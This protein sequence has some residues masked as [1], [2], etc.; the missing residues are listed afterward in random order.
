MIDKKEMFDIIISK[1]L[2]DKKQIHEKSY[3]SDLYDR[4]SYEYSF[5]LFQIIENKLYVRSKKFPEF[6]GRFEG[7]KAHI[8]KILD[9]Y[10]LP[11]MEFVY[12]DGDGLNT[13]DLILQSASC[14]ESN[15]AILVPDWSFQFWPETYLFDYGTDLDKIIKAAE[16]IG[17][18]IKGW[19]TKADVVF[20]RG[21]MNN[22]YREQY[23]NRGNDAFLDTRHIP[24]KSSHVPPGIPNFDISNPNG[25]NGI[26]RSENS[27]YKFLLHLNGG[28]DTDYS[29]GLRF[30]LACCSLVFYATNS[31]QREWWNDSDFFKDG[32]HYIHVTNKEDLKNKFEYFISNENEALRIAKNGFDFVKKYL[33]P[34]NVELYY[35]ELLIRYSNLLK[36]RVE[37]S[38]EAVHIEMYRRSSE[39]A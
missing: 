16:E 36:Y 12:F 39:D 10:K 14:N 38:P 28:L 8:L 35:K 17:T 32:E 31:K 5:K 9:K 4:Y 21:S 15:N 11:D 30:R 18:D 25:I 34:E 3:I 1:Q 13:N 20:L 6:E 24:H 7:V 19:R 33:S 2:A 23:L 26:E 37:L 27:K 29:S 22:L